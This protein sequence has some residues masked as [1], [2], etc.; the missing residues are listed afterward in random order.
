MV[1]ELLLETKDPLEDK[2]K[3]DEKLLMELSD[4][5]R[6]YSQQRMRALHMSL[7]QYGNDEGRMTSKEMLQA[8]Q[9]GGR[10]NSSNSSR[11]NL[12]WYRNLVFNG[13]EE[14]D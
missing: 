9:V 11:V 4:I 6:E 12:L 8:L 14:D 5:V 3:Q 1:D 7:R 2:R 10:K 13:K